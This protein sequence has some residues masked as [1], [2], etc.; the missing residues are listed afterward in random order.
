M[1]FKNKIMITIAGFSLMSSVAN[2]DI[3]FQHTP[4]AG[5]DYCSTTPGKWH[6]SGSASDGAIKCTYTGDVIVSATSNPTQFMMDVSMKK[7]SGSRA[8]LANVNFTLPADCI[9]NAI[10][11]KNEY[12]DL[13]GILSNNGKTA[14]FTGMIIIPDVG[15]FNVDYMHLDKQQ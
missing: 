6:G 7:S 3:I 1:K 9:N 13:N 10:T 8:C 11:V 14:D 5:Q 2:A 4:G 15:S 12:A